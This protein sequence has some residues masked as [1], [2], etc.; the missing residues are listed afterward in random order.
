MSV[1]L[2]EVLSHQLLTDR[3]IGG[4]ALEEVMR[5]ANVGERLAERYN[6]YG[7]LL[8]YS[9]VAEAMK[10]ANLGRA[11]AEQ[12]GDYPSG[13]YSSAMGVPPLGSTQQ[14]IK[15]MEETSAAAARM[16]MLGG[17]R[18]LPRQQLDLPRAASKA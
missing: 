4:S 10:Q 7:H 9:A 14:F 16:L 3:V 2:D 17:L 8:G 11:L 5:Q 1:F 12:Y 13:R 18:R 15:K 6:R